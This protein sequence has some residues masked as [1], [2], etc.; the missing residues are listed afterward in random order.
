MRLLGDRTPLLFPK[1]TEICYTTTRR[2][3]RVVYCDCL[4]NSWVHS[5]GGSNPSPSAIRE[6]CFPQA[7]Y[8]LRIYLCAIRE[9]GLLSIRATIELS[10]EVRKNLTAGGVVVDGQTNNTARF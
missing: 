10:G 5:P 1:R 3:G 4:E 8:F 7:E 2:D 6:G 9:T